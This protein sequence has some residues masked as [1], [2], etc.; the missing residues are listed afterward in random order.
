VPAPSDRPSIVMTAQI[1]L[2][3]SA[4]VSRP[5]RIGT[6]RGR[7]V[8]CFWGG[9]GLR[10]TVGVSTSSRKDQAV[11]TEPTPPAR[12]GV[13]ADPEASGVGGARS[14]GPVS[15][16]DVCCVDLCCVD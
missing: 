12:A 2:P 6:Q 15:S 16:V 7:R 9:A 11:V 1:A 5:S 3:A 10:M 8:G 4:R 13:A 14:S